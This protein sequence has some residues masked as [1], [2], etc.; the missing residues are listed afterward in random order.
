MSFAPLKTNFSFA[1]PVTPWGVYSGAERSRA[2]AAS[3]SRPLTASTDEINAG[4]KARVERRKKSVK[5]Q[6]KTD[7]WESAE[8]AEERRLLGTR[9]NHAICA[10]TRQVNGAILPYLARCHIFIARFRQSRN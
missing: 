8:S 6:V 5:E 10:L 1:K 9:G 4:C 2:S 7:Q 3:S